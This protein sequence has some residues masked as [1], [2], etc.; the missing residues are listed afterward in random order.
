MEEFM[1]QGRDEKKK[2]GMSGYRFSCDGQYMTVFG[3]LKEYLFLVATLWKILTRV[4]MELLP[5]FVCFTLKLP[6]EINLLL[7]CRK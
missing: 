4:L 5:Q 7:S 2:S 3:N 6:L 1:V